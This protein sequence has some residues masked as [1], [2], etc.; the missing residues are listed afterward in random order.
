MTKRMMQTGKVEEVTD[1]WSLF[2]D[3]EEK[4]DWWRGISEFDVDTYFL[5]GHQQSGGK[6]RGEGEVFA[7]EI[8]E[9]E[10]PE[11]QAEDL[12]EFQKIV[13]SGALKVL[14]LKES[15]RVLKELEQEQKLDRVLPS[16]MVRRYKPG[17]APGAPRS[18]KSRFC[19]RGDKDPDAVFLS[20][21]APR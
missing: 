20:R 13:K 1:E 18:K 9:H 15:Q 7:H 10:W 5:K 17:D 6:K 11:W 19:I 12:A 3:K 2:A 21:F 4:F 8:P 14:S 16:R